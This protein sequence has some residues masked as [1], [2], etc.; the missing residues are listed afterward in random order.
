MNISFKEKIDYWIDQNHA[1]KL[2]QRE[3]LENA[4]GNFVEPHINQII[5]VNPNPLLNI[6]I[7]PYGF[8]CVSG[9]LLLVL[10][11]YFG[12]GRSIRTLITQN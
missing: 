1:D 4:H 11:F 9:W 10:V 8:Y 12:M 7:T 5:A 3:A 6:S 2:K